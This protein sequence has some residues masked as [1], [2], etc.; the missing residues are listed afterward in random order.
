MSAQKTRCRLISS[1]G[2]VGAIIQSLCIFSIP[3]L[4]LVINHVGK[5]LIILLHGA[6]GVGKTSTAGIECGYSQINNPTW[7]T[8]HTECV[9]ELC[10]RPLYPITCG[11]LGITA[12]DVETRLK[13]IFIQAQRWKCVLLLDEVCFMHLTFH[14]SLRLTAE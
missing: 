3:V 7:L 1:V 9:A 12:E 10:K 4:T 2:R 5:G 13:R 11:D 6:P 8:L 14:V